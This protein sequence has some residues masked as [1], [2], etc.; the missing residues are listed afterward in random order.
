MSTAVTADP[1]VPPT[2]LV[3]PA[4][5]VRLEAGVDRVVKLLDVYRTKLKRLRTSYNALDETQKPTP[6]SQAEWKIWQTAQSG[7]QEI[8]NQL[9]KLKPAV[10]N[11]V[12][13]T[14][15][16]IENARIPQIDKIELQLKLAET[17]S[18]LS[19]ASENIH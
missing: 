16:L 3:S 4:E 11:L 18:A 1:V 17:E 13:Y 7:K 19:N 2:E 9:R 15:G 12:R 14:S 8:A 5:I 10:T 6:A